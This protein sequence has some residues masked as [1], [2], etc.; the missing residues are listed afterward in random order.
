M[1][2][3]YHAWLGLRSA[4]FYSVLTAITIPYGIF[5]LC[6]LPLPFSHHT[7]HEIIPF[8]VKSCCFF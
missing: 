5:C 2:C 8:M 1:K 7:R 4:L 3:L 6:C